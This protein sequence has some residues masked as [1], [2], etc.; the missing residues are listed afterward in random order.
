MYSSIEG[1]ASKRRPIESSGI[2]ELYQ[3]V[4]KLCRLYSPVFTT[5]KFAHFFE[6]FSLSSSVL[7]N[8]RMLCGTLSQTVY[9]PQPQTGGK[10]KASI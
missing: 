9:W 4:C 6:H 8:G 7:N 5:T 3:Q 2:E 10:G 1:V